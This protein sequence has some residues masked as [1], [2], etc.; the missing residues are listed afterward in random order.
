LRT[1][2]E[3]KFY[4]DKWVNEI[5]VRILN[6]RL[7]YRHFFDHRTSMCDSIDE[8]NAYCREPEWHAYNWV[9]SGPL[10]EE[11]STSEPIPILEPMDA[12]LND[13]CWDMSDICDDYWSYELND[14]IVN[15]LQY[16]AE[17]LHIEYDWDALRRRMAS[18]GWYAIFLSYYKN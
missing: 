18:G 11:S 5:D 17:F 9:V 3:P 4:I 1:G 7:L 10:F 8:L 2:I 12:Y 13:K 14:A 16:I 15:D 6:A